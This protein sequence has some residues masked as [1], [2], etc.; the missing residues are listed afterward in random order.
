MSYWTELRL[1]TECE[2]IVGMYDLT[3]YTTYCLQAEPAQALDLMTRYCA[4]SADI[5]HDA[6]GW[7]VKG[8]GDAGLFAFPAALADEAVAAALKLQE[9]GDAWL[10]AEN[11][12]GRVRTIMHVGPV[13][14]GRVGAR[15]REQLDIFG[16]TV[17]IV[18]SRRFEGYL[19]VTP[20]LFRK[21]SSAGRTFF[22]KHT[23]P[24]YYIGI[25]DPRPKQ[26]R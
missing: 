20:E 2:L 9:V 6:G 13:A 17:N 4:L 25:D 5:I 1:P 19:S 21:L 12:K 16:R 10:A 11:Y 14:I 7:F 15:G 22:K 26:R 8:I 3:A 24:I 23:P 18:G